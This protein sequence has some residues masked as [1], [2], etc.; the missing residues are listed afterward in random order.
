MSEE[1]KVPL[2]DMVMCLSDA[3][4]LLSPYLAGHHKRVAYI[5]AS[6]ASEYGMTK[7]EEKSIIISG[8][9]HDAGAFSLSERIDSF[10]WKI[11]QDIWNEVEVFDSYPSYEY[12]GSVSHSELGYQLIKQFSPFNKLASLVRYHH[13][14]WD[15]GEGA[16]FKGEEVPIGSHILHLADAVDIL[17]NRDKEVINQS[18]KICKKILAE[19]G[20]LF[21]PEVVDAF[22]NLA[23]RESFWFNIVSPTIIRNLKKR[24]DGSNIE[25]NRETL[26]SL[27]KFFS[28]IIDFRSR[29][30]ATHSSGVA[31]SAEALASLMGMSDF[32]CH[33][34]KIAG[35]LHDL[36]KLAV[37]P[38]ILNKDAKLTK[39]EFNIIKKHPFY[40]YQIL[41]RV[42]GL[43]EIK[44]WASLH[45]ERID[46][47][48]YPFKSDI[49]DIPLG[50]RIMAVA[51][52][53]TAITEDRP[54]RKG[55][56]KDRALKIVDDMAKDSA[57]DREVALV[58]KD[59]Y[60]CINEVRN[61]T[62]MNKAKEY[63]FFWRKMR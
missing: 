13:I 47:K 63:D 41:D 61:E 52:V 28:Q 48:G 19:S 43:E 4:D 35:Y 15:G 22:I 14:P 37:P 34:I 26:L 31:V 59:N 39:E 53:F 44:I 40:T 38:E 46:G 3:M 17:I 9:L 6:I 36:G 45:H 51:D 12:I 24:I 21:V 7:E 16:T 56:N 10:N 42:Q 18:E 1:L 60:K 33:K 11:S 29:F 49:D 57:L 54:Y 30:T 58:L 5:A 23:K 20:K 55:M 50:S 32:D 25:L 8:A 2:F 27:A 62:Q